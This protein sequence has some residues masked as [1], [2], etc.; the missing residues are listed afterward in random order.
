MYEKI[1]IVLY[2][3]SI[4]NLTNYHHYNN[5]QFLLTFKTCFHNTQHHTNNRGGKK[6]KQNIFVMQ[7]I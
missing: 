1:P 4:E 5:S 3:T 2:A 6:Q 7:N